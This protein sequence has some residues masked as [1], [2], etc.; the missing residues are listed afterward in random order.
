MRRPAAAGSPGPL[1]APTT[2]GRSGGAVASLTTI[3]PA[4]A[5]PS[6]VTVAVAAGPVTTN[7]LWD[8]PTR[9]KWNSPLWT[10]TDIR[11]WHLL[12]EDGEP[13]DRAQRAAHLDRRP[14]GPRLV[15][16]AGEVEELGVALRT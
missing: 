5:V 9:K 11:S 15:R 6:M 14:A 1:A 3:S 12:A 7:S 8:S 4:S 2:P 16:L 10:P 13:S